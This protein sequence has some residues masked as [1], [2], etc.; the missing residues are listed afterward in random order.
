MF[1]LR[2]SSSTALQRYRRRRRYVRFVSVAYCFIRCS[3]HYTHIMRLQQ[4]RTRAIWHTH[5]HD[6]AGDNNIVRTRFSRFTSRGRD[7][8]NN[9]TTSSALHN[10]IHYYNARVIFASPLH[11]VILQ[12]VQIVHIC[13]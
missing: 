4:V 8:E 11:R 13:V 1:D 6:F 9:V 3:P 5:V 7:D 10:I 2:A 12:R